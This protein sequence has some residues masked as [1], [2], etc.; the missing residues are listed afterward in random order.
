[1]RVG[2]E[3]NFYLPDGTMAGS[4]GDVVTKGGPDTSR[5]VRS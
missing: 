4:N 5:D 3:D 1:M 2:L